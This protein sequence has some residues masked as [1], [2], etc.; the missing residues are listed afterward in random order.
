VLQDQYQA[1][2]GLLLLVYLGYSYWARLDPRYPVAAALVL[3]VVAAAL[4][5]LGEQGAAIVVGVYVLLL[6][7]GGVALLV[8]EHLRRPRRGPAETSRAPTPATEPTGGREEGA[9]E[10]PPSAGKP[11]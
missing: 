11:A 10:E 4:D 6:L 2:F 1:I 5:A 3:L 9:R 8:A 7:L